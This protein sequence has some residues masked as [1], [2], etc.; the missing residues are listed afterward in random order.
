MKK[1]A[2]FTSLLK[3]Y[4]RFI[5][6]SASGRR[7]KPDGNRIASG[8][9]ETYRNCRKIMEG[10][11]NRYGDPK[12]YV[13]Y[14]VSKTIVRERTRYWQ[15]VL[16]RFTDYLRSYKYSDHYVCL[17]LKNLRC[18]M[19]FIRQERGI[20][21][22]VWINFKFPRIAH[23]IPI[24]LSVDHLREL[25]QVEFGNSYVQSRLR[26]VRDIAL[27][28]CLTA[29]RYSDLMALE[30]R[31]LVQHEGKCW[32]EN[33]SQKTGALTRVLLPEFLLVI[34]RR[35]RRPRR[36]HI[37]P[38]ISNVNLNIQV[39]KLGK[40][41]GWNETVTKYQSGKGMLLQ[42]RIGKFYEFLTTHTFRRTGISIMLQLGVPEQVVRQISG[43]SPNSHEFHRYVKTAQ[44]WQ[45]EE[46]DKVHGI[47]TTRIS[48]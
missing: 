25:I 14:S 26:I 6:Y 48:K 13:G 34:L 42:V 23:P 11:A 22:P 5:R 40:F 38:G 10:F 15:H 3:E 36:T 28:G 31:Q 35:Y 8:T 18:V 43:H 20:P 21:D 39:K 33:Q 32:L 12:I 47:L 7:R 45:D 19:Q 27:T 2:Q 9:I 4:D 24:T 17:N 41:L 29:L 30:W 16:Y 44:S 1:T 46:V 37:F